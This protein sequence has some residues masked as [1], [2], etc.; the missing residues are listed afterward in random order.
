METV[1]NIGKLALTIV[2]AFLLI[3]TSDTNRNIKILADKINQLSVQVT[4][5]LIVEYD[6][7]NN[8]H[9]FS[10]MPHLLLKSN[11][12]IIKGTL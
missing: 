11:P 8:G 10:L 4:S 6:A 9:C 1:E 5:M 3:W 7:R 12:N 2:I